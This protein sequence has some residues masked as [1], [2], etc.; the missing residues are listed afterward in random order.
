MNILS[1]CLLWQSTRPAATPSFELTLFTI[2]PR[3]FSAL[4]VQT[5]SKHESNSNITFH[6]KSDTYL[7]LCNSC[8]SFS[9]LPPKKQTIHLPLISFIISLRSDPSCTS[10]ASSNIPES[11]LPPISPPPTLLLHSST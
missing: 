9:L 5:K 3:M 10:L 8:L 4:T 11:L 2:P 1:I 7:H 6:L